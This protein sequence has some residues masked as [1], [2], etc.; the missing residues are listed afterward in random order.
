MAVFSR[1]VVSSVA[2]FASVSVEALKIQRIHQKKRSGRGYCAPVKKCCE[3]LGSGSGSGSCCESYCG[4]VGKTLLHSLYIICLILAIVFLSA[5][6]LSDC[7]Y[8]GRGIE[9][10]GPTT[11]D[12]GG[13]LMCSSHPICF[14][15]FFLALCVLTIC[16]AKNHHQE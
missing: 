16:G 7:G 15:F 3:S 4:P 8:V 2:L 13:S 11:T 1:F 6:F 5:T 9:F 10:E 12:N 14:A